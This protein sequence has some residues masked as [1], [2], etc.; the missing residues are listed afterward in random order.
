[1]KIV[2]VTKF[3]GSLQTSDPFDPRKIEPERIASKLVWRSHFFNTRPDVWTVDRMY[4]VDREH[5]QGKL[6]PYDMLVVMRQKSEASKP[7]EFMDSWLTEMSGDDPCAVTE[8]SVAA[9]TDS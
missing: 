9:R 6:L 1:M 3:R 4:V 7:L 8:A 5:H 2:V